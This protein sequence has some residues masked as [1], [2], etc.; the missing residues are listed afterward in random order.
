M[1]QALR[2]CSIAAFHC[3]GCKHVIRDPQENDDDDLTGG[4]Y[5]GMDKALA[6]AIQSG[7]CPQIVR[8]KSTIE[9]IEEAKY[10][11]D[12]IINTKCRS[13]N[14]IHVNIDTDRKLDVPAD[15]ETLLR[16]LGRFSDLPVTK[17]KYDQIWGT[18]SVRHDVLV[19][20]AKVDFTLLERGEDLEELLKIIP[21]KY[22]DRIRDLHLCGESTKLIDY[23]LGKLAEVKKSR[24]KSYVADFTD[25]VC[26]NDFNDFLLAV[27]S[28][29]DIKPFNY[30]GVFDEEIKRR[31]IKKGL[32]NNFGADYPYTSLVY[33]EIRNEITRRKDN[34]HA[35]RMYLVDVLSPFSGI[36]DL[37]YAELNESQPESVFAIRTIIFLSATFTDYS[38]EEFK[39][40]WEK[41][42]KEVRLMKGLTKKERYAKAESIMRERYFNRAPLCP[43]HDVCHNLWRLLMLL[44]DFE[45]CI[46]AALLSIGS[47]HDYLYYETLASV[48]L[49]G[50]VSGNSIMNITGW[51]KTSIYS[52]ATDLKHAVP[53]PPSFDGDIDFNVL[54][55]S[56]SNENIEE[57]PK[58]FALPSDY[59]KAK[60]YLDAF[61]DAGL[62]LGDYSWN[63]ENTNYSAAWASKT[64]IAYCEGM[65]H[66]KIGELFKIKNLGTYVT[67]ASESSAAKSLI[68]DVLKKRGLSF[69]NK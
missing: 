35:L 11:D 42:M 55:H 25:Y 20:L 53:V 46:E 15:R 56:E 5:Y 7:D 2:E 16:L 57:G 48:R 69:L 9:I 30:V 17:C 62:L 60:E 32:D 63:R 59:S 33:E 65:T 47:K 24:I 23:Y 6:K 8:A 31:F 51:T 26:G 45:S 10:T 50:Q 29:Y 3:R 12:D 61:K 18:M 38:N 21:I 39:E 37:L 54:P 52:M 4:I 28:Y 67:Y 27:M 44:I 66:G 22:Y 13:K 19:I 68:N 1:K 43:A 14:S 34:E 64:I 40:R 36:S 49:C 58:E 41:T